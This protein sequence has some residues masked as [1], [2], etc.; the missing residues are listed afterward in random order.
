MVEGERWEGEGG[1]K[2]ALIV[3]VLQGMGDM[4]SS[5]LRA[6]PSE[7]QSQIKYIIAQLNSGEHWHIHDSL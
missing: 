7:L 4:L 6:N 1:R 2:R 5:A 3:F